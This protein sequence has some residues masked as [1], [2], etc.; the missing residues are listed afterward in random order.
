MTRVSID[1]FVNTGF[2][3]KVLVASLLDFI[4]TFSKK[5]FNFDTNNPFSGPS[6][7]FHEKTITRLSFFDGRAEQACDDPEFIEMLYATLA[8]WGMHRMG[9]P[10]NHMI[11]FGD[12]KEVIIGLGKSIQELQSIR[13]D[14]IANGYDIEDIAL[15]D[16]IAEKV[17]AI[18]STLRIANNEAR[19][20]AGTKVLHHL[21]PELV[22]PIDRTYSL[23]MFY[24]NTHLH[25]EQR[26]FKQL[27]L[28]YYIIARE[29]KR[30]IGK[31]LAE[32]G[33]KMNTSFTKVIDNAIVGRIFQKQVEDKQQH[34]NVVNI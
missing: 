6:V 20:V 17:W 8:C 5:I 3:K 26:V 25:D 16:T 23:K 33:H 18:I 4:E 27:F 10:A 9:N 30:N 7:Y 13:I 19:L 29:C 22:P 12:F 14:E 31:I 28:C 15:V 21:L 24:G 34:I 2:T 32:S 1:E 11:E